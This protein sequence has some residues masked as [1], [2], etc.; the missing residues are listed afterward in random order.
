MRKLLKTYFKSYQIIIFS[1]AAV[2]LLGTFLL[3]LPIASGEGFHPSISDALFTSTSAV[4]VTGLVVRDTFMGWSL[5]GQ[6]VIILL[7][8]VGG[9]GVITIAIL[10]G[11]FSH[12]KI[13]LFQRGI[14][15]EAISAEKIGG[16]IRFTKSILKLTMAVEFVGALCLMPTFCRQ[17]GLLEGIG[18]SFFHSIS[19]FCNAG[20]DL[21]GRKSP[22]VSLTGYANN[23]VL[24]LVIM[25]LIIIGGIGFRTWMDIGSSKFR[26][27]K[28]R[29]QTKVI[30]VTTL[31]LILVPTVYFFFFEFGSMPVG[32]RVLASFFQAVTPRTA[33]FNTV[34]EAS[35]SQTGQMVT[36]MLM[37]IGGAP[38]STAGGMK[39]TTIAVLLASAL[40]V[41]SH[42]NETNMFRRRI[43]P[44]ILRKASALLLM[45]LVLFMTAAMAISRIEGLPLLSCMFE[46]ASAIGTV[47]LTLGITSGL[48]QVS[49]L[50]LIILM[51]LGR[52][53]GLT[54]LFATFKKKNA[55]MQMPKED[56]AV[57]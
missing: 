27:R 46:T 44:E 25:L 47:G 20:F 48:S 19:A 17:F 22:F 21:C 50:I 38:G 57:G 24:N 42:S 3:S 52:V 34:D 2:I 31:F 10:I 36:I 45:Y 41:F 16:I 32:K 54:I 43:A 35:L 7:I 37:L 56:I 23:I 33:G 14:M 6:T 55:D 12:R 40:A 8:Q 11:V 28:Y 51:F 1:F 5:F 53:G 13:S 30:L 9:M 26:I 4:C 29:L 18:Y 39:V 49:R 15:K